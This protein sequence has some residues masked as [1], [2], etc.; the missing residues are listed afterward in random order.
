MNIRKP[1]VGLLCCVGVS[2]A[3]FAKISPDEADALGK[4][5]TPIGAER[6]GNSDGSIPEWTGGILTPPPGFGDSGPYVDPF[7][8]DKPLFVITAQNLEQYKD[9][10]TEGQLALFTRYPDAF[11]M[12]VFPTRR[13]ASFPEEVY[14]ATKEAAVSVDFC[15]EKEVGKR[16][17][18]CLTGT[19]EGGGYPFPIPKNGLELHWNSMLGFVG[20]YR[21]TLGDLSYAVTENGRFSKNLLDEWN[22]FPY[23]LTAPERSY[24]EG[25][26]FVNRLGVAIQCISQR[27]IAPPRSAG[28]L[29]G[30]C[31]YLQ[32]LRLQ[33]YIY[34]PGQRRV[35]KAPEI[36]FY[37]QPAAGSEGLHTA[38]SRAIFTL[39]GSEEWFDHKIK[40]KSEKFISYNSYELASVSDPDTF[41]K[42]GVIDHQLVRYE[43]H[44]VWEVESTLRPG[45]RHLTPKIFTYVD[46]DS[47]K[48]ATGDR[49][50]TQGRLWKVAEAYLMN[51]YDAKMT[52]NFGIVYHDMQNGRYSTYQ[53]WSRRPDF[54]NPPDLDHFTPQ[55]LR[56]G[57]VR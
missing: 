47:W 5:L 52:D 40:G 43:L 10:L 48:G 15:D 22:V 54:F 7:A 18:R 38:D 39:T 36:G 45:F 14:R 50:D 21:N 37:D 24:Y 46:E 32:D 28:Q 17:T 51:Y 29:I 35:R 1:L 8:E 12:R 2:G 3:A 16:W 34:I 30:G 11:F 19:V 27:I 53:S 41:I 42:A 23:W 56:R 20:K 31:S 33:A 26:D 4:Q 44:R 13:S 9:N 6:A 25:S 49:F 57:G 55:G